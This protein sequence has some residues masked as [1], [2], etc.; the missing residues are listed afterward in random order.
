MFEKILRPSSLEVNHVQCLKLRHKRSSCQICLDNC[1]SNAISFDESLKIDN[2]L[3]HGCGIC[4][5]LC[6]T[7]VFELKELS[8]ELLLASVRG[9]KV[10][11]FTCSLSQQV[12]DGSNIPCLGYLHESILLGAIGYGTQAVKL[13][14]THCKKCDYAL[15]LQV[16]ARSLRRANRILAI[17]GIPR[18]ISMM[19]KESV[20]YSL[21]ERGLSS[22]REFF[23]HLIEGTRGMAAAAIDGTI[24]NREISA[25][26][27]VTLESKL[28]KKQS[29]LLEHLKTL[30]SPITHSTEADD[31]PFA[32]VTIGDRCNGCGMCCTFCPTGALKSYD[33][34]DRQVIDFNSG[35]CL[36]CNLCCDICPE[37]AISYSTHIDPYDL[38]TGSR[39]I[40]VKHRKSVC[41]RCGQTHIAVSGSTLCLDCRKA[42]GLEEWVITKLA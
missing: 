5:K 40:L 31:M 25:R 36:A 21:A 18:K 9:K 33:H 8:Y 10:V 2:S 12:S 35:Y 30:G 14:I 34:G 39:K 42:N 11:E 20:G 3:C 17:F 37:G 22:R 19:T 15:G 27:K 13:N 16:A 32:Q 1:P 4:V 24:S 6:P 26:T 7:N 41:S 23:S 38:I 28:P 29:F